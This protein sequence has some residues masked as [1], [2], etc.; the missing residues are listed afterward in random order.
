MKAKNPSGGSRGLTVPKMTV[1]S[2]KNSRSGIGSELSVEDTS[3]FPPLRV[4]PM[5]T[6]SHSIQVDRNGKDGQVIGFREGVITREHIG[7]SGAVREMP[8]SI[9]KGRSSSPANLQPCV[10]SGHSGPAQVDPIDELVAEADGDIGSRDGGS[11]TDADYNM[12]K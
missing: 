9:M 11:L 1:V 12:Q 2:W 7:S 5:I 3:V 6:I 4:D 8:K 10:L